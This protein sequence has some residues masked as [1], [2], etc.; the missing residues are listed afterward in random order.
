MWLTTKKKKRTRTHSSD[1]D[2][3]PHHKSSLQREESVDCGTRKW[4]IRSAM[5]WTID[6][7]V[8]V[9]VSVCKGR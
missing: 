2:D 9:I 6:L 5:D 8:A 1:E 4:W 3:P 7:I